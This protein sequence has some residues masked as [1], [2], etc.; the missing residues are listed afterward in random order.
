MPIVPCR[1]ASPAHL[2]APIY[3]PLEITSRFDHSS[4]SFHLCPAPDRSP[5]NMP[6][7]LRIG[8]DKLSIPVLQVADSFPKAK[9]LPLAPTRIEKLSRLSLPISQQLQPQLA[10][11][12][13]LKTCAPLLVSP[14]VPFRMID[15]TPPTSARPPAS[16]P[17]V[18]VSETDPW[19][20]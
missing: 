1:R 16:V 20:L 17:N 19:G 11:L 7:L 8:P 15:P 4:P 3:A 9:F 18:C 10:V 5:R 13:C 12:T 6:T 14:W 2:P